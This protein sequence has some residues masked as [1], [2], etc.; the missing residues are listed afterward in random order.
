MGRRGPPPK[1]VNLKIVQ[2]NPGKRRLPKTRAMT[3]GTRAGC[4]DWLS[5]GAKAEWRRVAPELDRIGLLTSLDRAT[6]AGYCDA[7]DRWSECVRFT[8]KQGTHYMTP[9]GQLREWPQVSM[10]K[11]A[12]QAMRA[13]A[14][15]LG[16]TPT[17]RLRLNVEKEEVED[18][19]FEKFLAS[20]K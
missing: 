19:P 2:G 8:K 12:G 16:L 9:A 14:G 13:F 11:A 3:A 18:D 7:F 1:P 5:P 20:R 10:A 17:S 4:P 15:D 6:L